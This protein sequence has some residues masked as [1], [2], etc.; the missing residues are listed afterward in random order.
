[1]TYFAIGH[2]SEDFPSRLQYFAFSILRALPSTSHLCSIICLNCFS[3]FATPKNRKNKIIASFYQINAMVQFP[4]LGDLNN[5]LDCVFLQNRRVGSNKR[6]GWTFSS[7]LI[8][9]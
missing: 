9:G 3:D 5:L 4:F 1:M 2:P 6:I 8:K 7:N